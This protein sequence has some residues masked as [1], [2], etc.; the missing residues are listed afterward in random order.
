MA[1]QRMTADG[2]I[3]G[4]RPAATRTTIAA[5]SAWKTSSGGMAMVCVAYSGTAANIASSS[6]SISR[7]LALIGSSQAEDDAGALHRQRHALVRRGQQR[8]RAE[9]RAAAVA[10]GAEGEMRNRDDQIELAAQCVECH[11][12]RLADHPLEFVVARAARLERVDHHVH[13]ASRLELGLLDDPPAEGRRFLP[14]HVTKGV[15]ADVVAEGVHVV[16]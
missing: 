11:G 7:R 16:P 15:A 4:L 10:I 2:M 1:S 14:G 5:M 6:S 9:N 13:R 3:S 12:R 8:Q